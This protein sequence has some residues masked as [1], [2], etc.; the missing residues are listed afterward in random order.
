MKKTEDFDYE[1]YV[2][3]CKESQRNVMISNRSLEH[4]TILIANIVETAKERI[5]LLT[6]SCDDTFYTKE[7]ILNQF[8]SFIN[9]KNGSGIIEI[10]FE[11]G[12]KKTTKCKKFI[13]SLVKEYEKFDK[14]TS[15]SLYQLKDNIYITGTGE[16]EDYRVHYIVVDNNKGFRYEKHS[17]EGETEDS[18]DSTIEA[19]ANF[20]NPRISESL[21][22]SFEGLK[23][24]SSALSISQCTG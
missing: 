4:A 8:L 5:C 3:D 6:R 17:L 2:K 18:D 14:T 19:K 20:G 10:I 15:L 23:K 11:E 21:Q 13:E 16:D 9:K 22:N 7:V 1:E 12:E 24:H